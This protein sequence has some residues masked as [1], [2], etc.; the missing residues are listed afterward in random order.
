MQQ[1]SAMERWVSSP[2]TLFNPNNTNYEQ[3][4]PDLVEAVNESQ[5]RLIKDAQGMFAQLITDSNKAQGSR[6]GGVL[7]D[8]NKLLGK[9][10]EAG[11][12]DWWK[13]RNK[14]REAWG[15]YYNPTKFDNALIIAKE[16]ANTNAILNES[17][18]QMLASMTAVR[19]LEDSGQY[20]DL[21]KQLA[22]SRL[23]S[24][25][26]KELLSTFFNSYYSAWET[27]ASTE[28]LTYRED[29]S[30]YT[31]ANSELSSETLQASKEIDE[32]IIDILI[33]NGWSNKELFKYAFP[34]MIK[35]HEARI[36][37][38]GT[39]KADAVKK[40]NYDIRRREFYSNLNLAGS[41][42]E[43]V[44]QAIFSYINS[45]WG[46]H[47]N[48][49]LA[50]AEILQLYKD[51]RTSGEIKPE[52][53]TALGDYE[54]TPNDWAAQGKTDTIK[55]KDHWPAW[56]SEL[57]KAEREIGKDEI[58]ASSDDRAIAI[59]KFRMEQ[60]PGL[61]NRKQPPSEEDLR[62]LQ[63]EH[64]KQ[65]G[66][67]ADWIDNWMSK[68]EINDIDY[69]DGN[70]GLK[71][72]YSRGE[73]ITPEDVAGISDVDKRIEWLAKVKEGGLSKDQSNK[74]TAW[75]N[76]QALK[77][78]TDKT[79]DAGQGNPLFIA[80]SQQAREAF[81]EIYRAERAANQSHRSAMSTA[82]KEISK[83]IRD[84]VYDSFVDYARDTGKARSLAAVKKALGS[85]KTLIIS[86]EPWIGEELPL[87]EGLQVYLTGDGTVPEY[88]KLIS[89]D[90]KN[91]NGYQLLK[92]RLI[93]TK[94]INDDGS[95]LPEVENL[96]KEDQSLL[97]EK[98]NAS[99]TYQVTQNNSDIKWMVDVLNKD[100]IAEEQV[101][102]EQLIAI[103]RTVANN[104]NQLNSVNSNWLRLVEIDQNDLNEYYKLIGDVP[105]YLRLENLT[106]GVA[107][108]LLEDTLIQNN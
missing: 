103:L 23:S 14:T 29:G 107:K 105:P 1:N 50:K 68:E 102:E 92:S 35:R 6:G 78:S 87:K 9:A 34:E 7:D 98:P 8:I 104:Y 106:P 21:Q 33:E 22:S 11:I 74:V 30:N 86:P 39:A 80:V 25:E 61:L 52:I 96:N 69:I 60:E 65:F 101:T 62:T 54:F 58:E 42:P 17:D 99:S 88:Y 91:I 43:D 49:Q 24:I 77:H 89:N 67:K 79:L 75:V 57:K 97:I 70:D 45:Y 85:D 2:T 47:G 63:L 108:A 46:Y 76:A 59:G 81:G 10:D 73:A 56:Y 41:E 5:D 3:T 40:T 28:L 83:N 55:V 19:E 12:I 100:K 66:V 94:L 27:K 18:N 37:K 38:W 44:G 90:L 84:G 48:R 95:K 26:K 72:R 31:L 32:P 20:L 51:G 16:K 71:E 36:Q 15:A 64:I 4:E 53:I 93:S 13:T 82:R